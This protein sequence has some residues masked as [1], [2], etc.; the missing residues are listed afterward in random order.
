MPRLEPVTIA[1]RFVILG[2][3]LV[4]VVESSMGCESLIAY[5]GVRLPLFGPTESHTE[6]ENLTYLLDLAPSTCWG[7][8][9]QGRLGT[10][11]GGLGEMRRKHFGSLACFS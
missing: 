3:I 1:V 5:E 8:G 6:Q 9:E 7:E 2:T 11:R 10:E 4:S